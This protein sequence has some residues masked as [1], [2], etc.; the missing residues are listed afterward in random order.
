MLFYS[1]VYRIEINKPIT[2]LQT[3]KEYYDAE[4]NKIT[5]DFGSNK[6]FYSY[7]RSG[8][9][10]LDEFYFVRGKQDDITN[11]KVFQDPDYSTGYDCLVAVYWANEKLATHLS[12]KKTE[13]S[14][15]PVAFEIPSEAPKTVWTDSKTALIELVYAFKAKG[16]F[17][18]GKA[19]L[20]DITDF[21]QQH[22]GVE[23]TNPTRDFQE[24]L[25]RKN[26]Y[27]IYL[28]GLKESYLQYIDK[29]ET[30]DRR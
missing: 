1:E 9:T 4:L 2:G 8:A 27:T 18:N 17:N 7:L 16:S 15:F 24:I 6:S 26:G 14:S 11:W 10:H 13:I 12:K 21:V 25:R 29:I 28:D 30:K 5:Q 20:K 23:I 22:F 3:L 19:T